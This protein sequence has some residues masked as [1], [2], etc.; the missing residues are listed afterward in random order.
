MGSYATKISLACKGMAHVKFIQEGSTD[1]P[2]INL[3]IKDGYP[4]QLIP[5]LRK[6]R[7]NMFKDTPPFWLLARGAKYAEHV[8]NLIPKQTFIFVSDNYLP[9]LKYTIYMNGLSPDEWPVI[10]LDCYLM[11]YNHKTNT[12]EYTTVLARTPLDTAEKEIEAEAAIH[13]MAGEALPEELGGRG[14]SSKPKR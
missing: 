7:D 1:F 2:I 13:A 4:D 11:S 14:G 6:A 9:N 12:Q 5:I 10:Q 8:F 3:F